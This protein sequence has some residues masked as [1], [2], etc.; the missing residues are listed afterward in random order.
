MD[1]DAQCVLEQLNNN[2]THSERDLVLL[3]LQ[4]LAEDTI[5]EQK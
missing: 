5:E 4:L 1:K 3:Q 2:L